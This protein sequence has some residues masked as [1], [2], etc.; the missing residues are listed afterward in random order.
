MKL[1]LPA[2]RLSRRRWIRLAAAV[3][4][5]PALGRAARA[6]SYP[7]RS[8]RL[9]VGYAPGG[10]TDITARLIA[11]RLSE[12]L[13][14]Q[15]IVENR[16]GATTNIATEQVVRAPADGYTLLMSTAANAINATFFERLNFDFVRD[17]APVA[18]VIRMQNVLEVHPDVPA[19]SVAALIAY[20]KANPDRLIAGSAGNGSPG[21]VSAELFKMMTGTRMLHVPYRGIAPALADLLGG[22]IHV[23]FDNM[24]TAIEPIRS[25]KLRALGV[26][27]TFR[28]PLLPD[29]PTIAES[30]PGY[31][32]SSWYGVSAPKD[33][34][35]EVIDR[36]NGAINAVLTEGPI[37]ARFSTLGGVP[38][39]G[40]AAAF[41]GL[42]ADETEKWGRVVRF[43]GAKPD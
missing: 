29:V 14:Q 30:V 39:A 37:V 38:L 23:L 19:R 5:L 25:G 31:E 9:I 41:G 10:A 7:S 40:S 21:H 15:F 42:I 24:A 35:S 13:G 4:A 16:P 27:T 2:P 43:S 28:S 8:V 6:Q 18:G 32:A 12:R 20:A 36:L 3:I 1:P 11:A 17:T 26:T 22:R 34:P 33:T